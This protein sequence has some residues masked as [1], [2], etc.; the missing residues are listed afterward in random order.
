MIMRKPPSEHG[1]WL[2]ENEKPEKRSLPTPKQPKTERSSNRP[3]G[4]DV[5][6]KALND[7]IQEYG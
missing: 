1:E 4:E 2:E 5:R 3:R 7:D 6:F